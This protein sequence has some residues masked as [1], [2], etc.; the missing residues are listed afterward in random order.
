MTDISFNPAFSNAPFPCYVTTAM[1]VPEQRLRSLKEYCFSLLFGFESET[2]NQ[3]NQLN[4]LW[5]AFYAGEDETGEL[6]SMIPSRGKN[7]F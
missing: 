2:A 5:L 6:K 1:F 7:H 4:K 3:H